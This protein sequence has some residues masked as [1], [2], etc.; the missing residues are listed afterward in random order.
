MGNMVWW[1]EDDTGDYEIGTVDASPKFSRED[2]AIVWKEREERDAYEARLTQHA[3]VL[4]TF[5]Q[6]DR[7]P[8]SHMRQ[9]FGKHERDWATQMSFIRGQ[10]QRLVDMDFET[11]LSQSRDI[12]IGG[13][14]H[15]YS[16]TSEEVLDEL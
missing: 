9:V 12:I 7:D 1:V 6:A 16:I 5:E 13:W 15:N 8:N 4:N 3:G 14:P 10:H 11:W 2:L